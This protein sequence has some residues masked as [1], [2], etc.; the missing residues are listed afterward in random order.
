MAAGRGLGAA[1][2][3]RLAAAYAA[4]QRGEPEAARA[5]LDGPAHE[6]AEAQ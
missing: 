4:F 2:D 1:I 5:T 6:Q 3:A